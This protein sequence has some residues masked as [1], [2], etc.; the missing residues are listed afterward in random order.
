MASPMLSILGHY[1]YMF[2]QMRCCVSKAS[3]V[4][5]QLM[6]IPKR[7]SIGKPFLGHKSLLEERIQEGHWQKGALNLFLKTAPFLLWNLQNFTIWASSH[8]S[9]FCKVYI[10]LLWWQCQFLTAPTLVLNQW[11]PTRK[12]VR[13]L[14]IDHFN[15]WLIEFHKT[16]ILK[17]FV[18]S[19]RYQK[20]HI[21]L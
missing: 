3:K 14:C 18:C 5:P 21:E 12:L 1:A 10:F 4:S 8:I 6:R 11:V 19:V 16:I 13:L 9:F 17:H 15:M 7:K 20:Q 2:N